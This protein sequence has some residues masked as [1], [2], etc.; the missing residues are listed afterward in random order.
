MSRDVATIS[1]S[2][3][4]KLHVGWAFGKRDGS[5]DTVVT[6]S[7]V[8]IA[9]AEQAAEDLMVEIDPRNARNLLEDFERVLGP[10]HCGRDIDAMT[11]SDRQSL[12]HQRWTAF[13]GQNIEYMRDTAAKVGEA[14]EVIEFWPSQA[15]AMQA[16]DRLVADGEQFLWMVRLDIDGTTSLFRAGESTAGDRLGTFA[17]SAS[18]CELRRIKPAHTDIVFNYVDYLT[19]DGEPLTLGVDLLCL[20]A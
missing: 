19:L 14:I 6:S 1:R 17:L 7:A 15:G 13:G 5:L 12:A 2:L 10:D 9:D 4:A 16:G 20:G 3:I 18:E 8:A 11:L